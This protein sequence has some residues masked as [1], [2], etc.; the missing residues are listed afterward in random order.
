MDLHQ[1]SSHLAD[2][3][4]ADSVAELKRQFIN[5]NKATVDNSSANVQP[6]SEEPTATDS[7]DVGCLDLDLP[8]LSDEQCVKCQMT[9]CAPS[10]RNSDDGCQQLEALKCFAHALCCDIINGALQNFEKSVVTRIPKTSLTEVELFLSHNVSTERVE[11]H[12]TSQ[13]RPTVVVKTCE[14]QENTGG[15]NSKSKRRKTKF[16]RKQERDLAKLKQ[17][18]KVSE[19]TYK[20]VLLLFCATHDLASVFCRSFFSWTSSCLQLKN[21]LWMATKTPMWYVQSV[22]MFITTRT[23]AS[24]ATTP[25]ANLV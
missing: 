22:W 16:K 11:L 8:V 10:D 14:R 12:C 24:L 21:T 19:A 20:H 9:H 4:V 6:T 15:S 23:S 1:Y 7:Q 25:S 17:M 13:V 3:I 2:A 18:T 5:K